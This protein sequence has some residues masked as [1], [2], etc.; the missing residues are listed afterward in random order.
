MLFYAGDDQAHFHRPLFA[1]YRCKSAA[2]YRM[3]SWLWRLTWAAIGFGG[4]WA[5]AKMGDKITWSLR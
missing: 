1:P 3:P 4:L 2:A 5:F